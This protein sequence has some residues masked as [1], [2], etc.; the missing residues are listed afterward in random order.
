MHKT[1]LCG[2]LAAAVGLIVNWY[3]ESIMVMQLLTVDECGR[4][5]FC[6]ESNG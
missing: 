2:V 4:Q 1:L 5:G 3:E 6:L